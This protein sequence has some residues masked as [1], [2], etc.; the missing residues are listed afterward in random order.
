PE[1]R[2]YA[3]RPA[4]SQPLVVRKATQTITL[5]APVEVGRDAGT[6]SV[7]ATTTSGLPVTLAI[8]D[9]EMATLDGTTLNIH[10]LGTVRLTGTQLRDANCAAAPPMTLTLRVIDPAADMPIRIHRAVSP[11]GD[12]IN[13]Y[14]V[15]EAIKDYPENRVYVF[16]RNGTMLYE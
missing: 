5:T 11:N 4:V 16:N 7:T 9:P 12:G 2:N 1:N 15:I 6:V 13:E 14:L 8:D 3:N 10:R